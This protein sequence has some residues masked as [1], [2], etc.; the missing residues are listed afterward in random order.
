M[1]LSSLP[2]RKTIIGLLLTILAILILARPQ[3]PEAIL[4]AKGGQ[5][6]TDWVVPETAAIENQARDIAL[7]NDQIQT[8]LSDDYGFLYA[9]PLGEGEIEPWQSRGC[10]AGDCA[11]VTFYDYQT[12]AAVEAIVTLAAKQV[13]AGWMDYDALPGASRQVL[14]R[15]WA[16]ASADKDVTAIIGNVRTA[17]PVMIPMSTWMLEGP[18]QFSWCV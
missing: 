16:I 17:E 3:T 13:I 11:Q 7:E 14:P 10:Q 6:Y 1:K 2:R 18:C 9:I 15:A 4:V 5:A 12:G 8:M